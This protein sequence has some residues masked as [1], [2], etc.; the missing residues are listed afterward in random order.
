MADDLAALYNPA[1]CRGSRGLL[2]WE[3]LLVSGGGSEEIR[4][5]RSE[6][7]P[8]TVAGARVEAFRRRFAFLSGASGA[9]SAETHR[10]RHSTLLAFTSRTM[11]TSLMT[12]NRAESLITQVPHEAFALV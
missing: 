6:Q 4:S 8:S 1:N 10:C 5:P 11:T 9:R 3:H 12:A 2:I 7:L